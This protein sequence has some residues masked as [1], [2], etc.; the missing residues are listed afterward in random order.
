MEKENLFFDLNAPKVSTEYIR[1]MSYNILAPSLLFSSV[2]LPE[3]ILEF[4][5]IYQWPYRSKLIIEIILKL[6]IDIIC[7]QELEEEDN[8]DF[9]NKLKE[10]NFDYRFKKRPKQNKIELKEGCGIFYNINK[11]ELIESFELEYKCKDSFIVNKE[12]VAIFILLKNKIEYKNVKN[13]DLLLI[14]CSHLLFNDKRGDIKLGQI[15]ELQKSISAIKIKYKQFNIRI[16][17]CC[18][19]NSTEIS[20]IYEY[21]TNNFLNCEFVDIRILSGQK[22]S[23]FK[24]NEFNYEY[25]MN[26]KKINLTLDY[27]NFENN[28]NWFNEIINVYPIIKQNEDKLNKNTKIELIKNE[29]YDESENLILKN[30]N[31]LISCYKEIIGNEP[32][33]TF[34]TDGYRG[35]V[36]YIF[37]SINNL[38]AKQILKIPSI[39]DLEN[40]EINLIPN[41]NNPS[42]HFPIVSDIEFI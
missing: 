5:E 41:E 21:L 39:S 12:N 42:D 13:N 15:Y 20:N 14:V 37:H 7:F 18:D 11:F 30:E 17:F 23:K 27:S 29:Y 19:L 35:T 9:L 31:V 34:Y 2:R 28:Q 36:D 26:N 25:Y 6:Q 8:E 16:I 40:K 10:N 3:E 22:Y 33:I 1:I 38:K 4:N 24:S 32:E